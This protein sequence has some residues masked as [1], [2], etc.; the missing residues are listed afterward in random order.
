MIFPVMFE[1]DTTD[2]KGALV[3]GVGNILLTDEG[4]GVRVVESFQQRYV[5][6]E[7]VDVL[8]GGT[9]GMDLLDALS[10][11][12]HIVIVDAVR[13]GA[14]PGTIVRL[15]GADV[16]ALFSNR[17]SPHQLGISDVLAILRL[18]DQE[19]RHIALI[20]IVPFDLDLGLAL[21]D[22]IAAR[23]DDMVELVAEELRS[24]GFSMVP[25]ARRS[26]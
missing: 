25:R 13:T 26:P 5:I 1:T 15:T 3:L 12:S 19:P 8:D 22:A 9:A 21:S 6:P 14:Q 16:P 20:G 4:V 11:R 23:V 2:G 18:V 10:A 24:H 7:G 17:I